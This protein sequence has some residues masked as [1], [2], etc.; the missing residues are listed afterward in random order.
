MLPSYYLMLRH[1]VR[2]SSTPVDKREYLQRPEKEAMRA[3]PPFPARPLTQIIL[4]QDEDQVRHAEAEIMKV[5]C[6]GFDTESKPVFLANQPKSGPHLLQIATQQQAFLC[7]PDFTAGVA[8]F[9]RV[10]ESEA[11]AKVGFG[12]KSD[13]GALQRAFGAR[14][15]TG[16]EL[17]TAVQRLGF[18]DKVGLQMAVAVVLGQYLQKSKK[19][20]TSNW[21]AKTL[22]DA[23]LLYAANDAFASLQVHLALEEKAGR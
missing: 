11:I 9:R 1:Q 19:V 18:R 14:L 21:A 3:L 4:L 8:L 16:I 10:I 22:S 17:S 13:R 5:S 15:R 2:A 23:Q 7:R 20:T 6:L 12:L